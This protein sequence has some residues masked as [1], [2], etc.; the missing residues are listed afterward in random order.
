MEQRIKALVLTLTMLTAQTYAA[1]SV[2]D[3]RSNGMG[4]T[5]VTT[6]NYLLAPFH[7]PALVAVNQDNDSLGILF[8]GIGANVRDTDNTLGT[9]DD[10]QNT[11]I[12]Y[13]DSQSSDL[14]I[15]NELNG[16]LTQLSNDK[17]MIVSG[18]A[19]A[20]VAIPFN[21]FSINVFLNGNLAL[22]GVTDISEN[23]G[24]NPDDVTDRY[25]SSN[26]DLLATGYREFG[27]AVAKRF[28]I[29]GQDVSIGV[30]PKFQD[31][32]TYQQTL[33]V[34]EFDIDNYDQTEVSKTA[35]N[36]DFGL[37]WFYQNFRVG[38]AAKDLFP[39]KLDTYDRSH[40]YQLDT[41]VTVS[42]AVEMNYFITTIDLD[43]TEQTRY[44]NIEDDTQFLRFW[45]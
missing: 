36:M 21:G 23:R 9:L 15:A 24:N 41:Q 13:Q 26:V 14:K 33:S 20:A 17:P 7:N 42:G 18:G 12:R 28:Y 29:I 31:I 6:S 22:F 35:L 8:P 25:N 40:Q 32:T 39:Q 37:L 1:S 5:G 27:V 4:N 19:T 45:D 2:S 10:L 30:T 16:Y 43:L 38:L 11:I 44:T 3:A 34:E